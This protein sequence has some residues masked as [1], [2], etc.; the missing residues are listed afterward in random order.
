[1]TFVWGF[2]SADFDDNGQTDIQDLDRLVS[3]VAHGAHRTLFDLTGDGMVDRQDIERWLVQAGS[4]NLPS[5]DP[6]S[7]GD[8]NLDGFVD[9]SDFN[10]WNTHKF[11][12]TGKWSW[13][14]FNADG[15]TDVSDFNE[16]NVNTFVS[17]AARPF[18]VPAPSG[19]PSLW[20]G[21]TSLLI[22]R[23]PRTLSQGRPI[24]RS[25]H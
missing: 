4:V 7:I 8:A 18:P 15:V 2:H 16:W 24:E 20:L 11:T 5:G 14:D 22:R 1:M 25:P 6:Y 21:V 12:N 19:T 17:A 3:E 13:G 23:S 10:I 9:V